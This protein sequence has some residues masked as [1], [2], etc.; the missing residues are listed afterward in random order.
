M[1]M[2]HSLGY[3]Q[4]GLAALAGPGTNLL[5][6][7]IF[8]TR[9]WGAAFAGLNL[10]LACFNMVPVGRLD[11]GRA[12][13]CAISLI[14]SPDLANEIGRCLDLIC[15]GLLLSMGV[16]LAGAGGNIT[17]LLVAV[18]LLAVFFSQ[19]LRQRNRNRACH[20]GRKQVK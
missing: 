8:C 7:L 13:N 19:N 16:F 1:V 3:W 9:E 18:W 12:L 5:L 14:L 11:G 10:L 4:E 6:A 17:L 2:A 20:R 15:T